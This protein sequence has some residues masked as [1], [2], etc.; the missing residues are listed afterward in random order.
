MFNNV[1]EAI[2]RE[3]KLY[4]ETWGRTYIKN[5][6]QVSKA[7]F[8]AKY[9]SLDIYDENLEKRFIIEH[10][11]LQFDKNDGWTSIGLTEK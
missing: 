6:I 7:M 1:D 10:K 2:T 8:R 5:K 9:A 4:I 3:L 11:Q